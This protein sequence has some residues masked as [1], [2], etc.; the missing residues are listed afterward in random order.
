MFPDAR[1]GILRVKAR[2]LVIP[3]PDTEA[4]KRL[5]GALLDLAN[6]C[7]TAMGRDRGERAEGILAAAKREMLEVLG[8]QGRGVVSPHLTAEEAASYLGVAY[9]TFRKKA[10]RIKKQPS[11]GRYRI[12]DLDEFAASLKPRKKR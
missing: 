4:D 8:D 7:H 5:W 10:T 6:L 11:T 12:E 1:T 9:S 2:P 3:P